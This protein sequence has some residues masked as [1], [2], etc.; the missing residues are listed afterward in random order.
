[1]TVQTQSHPGIATRTG[2]RVRG[3]KG[4]V[5]G[6]VAFAAAATGIGIAVSSSSSEA[7][8]TVIAPVTESNAEQRSAYNRLQEKGAAEQPE[9]V[10]YLPGKPGIK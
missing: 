10:W 9:V 1:M 4:F 8:A 6:A 2:T 5:V 7:P 3:L